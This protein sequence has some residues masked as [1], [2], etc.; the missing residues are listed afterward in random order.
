MSNQG[1]LT[2]CSIFGFHSGVNAMITVCFSYLSRCLYK[3]SAGDVCCDDFLV[4]SE[5][6]TSL[7]VESK[8]TTCTVCWSLWLELTLRVIG[9]LSKYP[10]I[11]NW[12]GWWEGS[13]L[14]YLKHVTLNI[15]I[16]QWKVPKEM[17]QIIYNLPPSVEQAFV[18]L[19]IGKACHCIDVRVSLSVCL[20][21]CLSLSLSLPSLSLCSF[22]RA[23]FV[24]HKCRD[25]VQSGCELWKFCENL[26]GY[27]SIEQIFERARQLLLVADRNVYE[28]S[29]ILSKY[30][31]WYILLADLLQFYTTKSFGMNTTLQ[32][33]I[34][35]TKTCITSVRLDQGD[36]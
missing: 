12:M 13:L 34:K 3:A 28:V 27:A 32:D 5:T 2:I 22:S 16:F 9:I 36:R 35:K 7:N 29:Y 31:R 23:V 26:T 18:Y 20:S 8:D 25:R 4:R 24:H 10:C 14:I 15:F 19:L 1:L 33:L 11:Y 6:F 17:H 21:V 30:V